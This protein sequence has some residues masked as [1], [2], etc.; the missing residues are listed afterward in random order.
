MEIGSR[1][2]AGTTGASSQERSALPDKTMDLGA[3]TFLQLLVTQLRYQDPFSGGQDM[4]DFMGQLAQFALL[5][6]AVQ[7]QKSLENFA[8]AQE[9]TLANFVAAQAPQQAL[10][11]LNKTVAVLDENGKILQ[12]AVT[13]VR[14]QAGNPCLRI[15]EKEYPLQAVLQVGNLPA[16]E[17]KDEEEE[18]KQ[19]VNTGTGQHPAGAVTTA[20][21]QAAAADAP[22]NTAVTATAGTAEAAE[23]AADTAGAAGNTAAATADAAAT[24]AEAAVA[25]GDAAARAADAAGNTDL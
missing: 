4:G 2:A 6:K 25:A 16:A 7:M 15:G 14:L 21:E 8:A 19:A 3:E 5:E 9:K 18:E 11:L 20:G 23:A 10:M 13:A 1:G 24:V 22:E 17:D 12:G